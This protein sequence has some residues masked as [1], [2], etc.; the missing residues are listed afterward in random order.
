MSNTKNAHLLYGQVGIYTLF[1][2][3][4]EF[5]RNRGLGCHKIKKKIRKLPRLFQPHF[6]GILTNF[7]KLEAHKK[8]K[9]KNIFEA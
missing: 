9:N 8:L 1:F 6:N 3:K 5:I 7:R 2:Y 4:R